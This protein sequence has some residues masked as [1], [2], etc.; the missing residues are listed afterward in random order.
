M[1]FPRK[2]VNHVDY[3]TVP[4]ESMV[5]KHDLED[6]SR[7]I[8]DKR[9]CVRRRLVVVMPRCVIVLNT[10]EMIVAAQQELSDFCH[11]S[12]DGQ[13]VFVVVLVAGSFKTAVYQGDDL[14]VL[15][16]LLEYFVSD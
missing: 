4:G 2:R 6:I 12:T 9:L 1:L 5:I 16:S 14:I 8:D 13:R 7:R 3:A 11:S 10:S 15:Q